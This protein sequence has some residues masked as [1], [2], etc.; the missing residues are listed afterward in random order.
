VQESH[1]RGAVPHEAS[2]ELCSLTQFQESDALG[3][4][5]NQPREAF[6]I[7]ILFFHFQNQHKLYQFKIAPAKI[8]IQT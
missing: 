7:Q 4:K 6:G 1:R 3:L 2:A 5:A 8:A